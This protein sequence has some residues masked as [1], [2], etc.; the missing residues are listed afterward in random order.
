MRRATLSASSASSVLC[1]A[2][3]ALASPTDVM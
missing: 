3:A 1:S 2:R